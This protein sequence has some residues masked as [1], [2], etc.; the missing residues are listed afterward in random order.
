MNVKSLVLNFSSNRNK[1]KFALILGLALCL[2]DM[3]YWYFQLL[4]IL[5]TIG[6][7]YLAYTDYKDKIK[8]TPQVFLTCAILLNPI[9]KISFDRNAWQV[10]DIILATLL[11]LS[12]LFEK[13]LKT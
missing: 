6:F 9:I 1:V 11:C 4:R 12:I 5:G 7:V 10:V 2:F 8:Y 13:K 3:P